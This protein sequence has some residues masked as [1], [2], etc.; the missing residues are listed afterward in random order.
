MNEYE[1]SVALRK[2]R[3]RAVALAV[4]AADP[5]RQQALREVLTKALAELDPEP[6]PRI[7]SEP[8]VM[9]AVKPVDPNTGGTDGQGQL[10]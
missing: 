5:G 8:E 10:L 1:Y 7:A 4:A 6:P 3:I 9:D 2:L